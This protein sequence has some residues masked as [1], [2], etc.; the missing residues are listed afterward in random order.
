M[1]TGRQSYGTWLSTTA[2]PAQSKSL[3]QSMPTV[4][5]HTQKHSCKSPEDQKQACESHHS[6][7]R[8]KS[9]E[10]CHRRIVLC[11]PLS[12]VTVPALFTM[13]PSFPFSFPFSLSHGGQ[14]ISRGNIKCMGEFFSSAT[15]LLY[16]GVDS[17]FKDRRGKGRKKESFLKKHIA[18][19]SSIIP[20]FFSL[21]LSFFPSLLSPA[22]QKHL[23]KTDPM[24]CH[25]TPVASFSHEY[26]H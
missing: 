22:S 20:S 15:D 7:R 9:D 16:I 11:L 3:T 25:Y 14:T 13:Q 17:H 5:I 18:Y 19:V 12:W 6:L 23:S 4:H 1:C 8:L 26:T 24:T 21:A 2:A 10:K